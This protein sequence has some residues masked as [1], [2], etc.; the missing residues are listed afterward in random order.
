MQLFPSL[1]PTL[2]HVQEHGII[3]RFLSSS[4]PLANELRVL[5][6]LSRGKVFSRRRPTKHPRKLE[7]VTSS[8]QGLV[9]DT[10]EESMDTCPRIHNKPRRALFTP[11]TVD[12]GPRPED[13]EDDRETHSS[14]VDTKVQTLTWAVLGQGRQ[15]FANVQAPF[16]QRHPNLQT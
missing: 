1:F 5:D 3:H 7:L 2:L 6:D 4:A 14:F 13:L 8:E 9:E 10:W 11:A 16:R 15:C 12:H